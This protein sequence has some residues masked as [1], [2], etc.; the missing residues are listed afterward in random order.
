MSIGSKT[1]P[2]S[3]TLLLLAA[4]LVGCGGGSDMAPVSGIVRLDG[5]PVTEGTVRFVPES[6]RGAKGT[7]QSDGT[8]TLGTDTRSDGASIGKH[9]VAIIAYKVDKV[10]RTDGGRPL[11]TG[12]TPLVPRH[13]MAPGTSGLEFEVKP[14]KNDAVFELKSE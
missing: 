6:G 11:I 2:L 8:F 12:S 5:N 1:L 10:E 14:G 13:Y 9:R 7:I 4:V 3:T